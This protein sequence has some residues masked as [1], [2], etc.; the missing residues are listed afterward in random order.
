MGK[1]DGRIGKYQTIR[2]LLKVLAGIVL[3]NKI[4]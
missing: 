3:N 4:L 2:L 1:E